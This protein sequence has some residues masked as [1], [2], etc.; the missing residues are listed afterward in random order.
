MSGAILPNARDFS[1]H[2]SKFADKSVSNNTNVTQIIINT[3]IEPSVNIGG[4]GPTGKCPVLIP[5]WKSLS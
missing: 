2:D 4:G 3:P 5:F 1:I